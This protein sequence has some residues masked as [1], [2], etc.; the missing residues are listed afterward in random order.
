[1]KVTFCVYDWHNFFGGTNTWLRRLLPALRNR[2]IESNVIFLALSPEQ[3][4]T[5]LPML[6]EKGFECFV[7]SSPHYTEDRM[8]WILEKLVE[9]PPDIFVP[10]YMVPAL[11][12][13]RWV[14]EAGIPTIGVLHSDDDYFRGIQHEFVFGHS[15]YKLSS[16][17]CVSKVLEDEVLRSHPQKTLVRRIPYG[18]PVPQQVASSPVKNLKIAYLGRF[19][20]TQKRISEVTHALCRATKEV[21]GTEAIMYGDGPD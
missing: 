18:V 17:V 5:L 1:M 12:A 7:I 9:H 16:I 15:E 19:V 10:N 3:E 8:N 6:R 14:Q 4:C 11:Y 21:S 20:E 2:G 13:S